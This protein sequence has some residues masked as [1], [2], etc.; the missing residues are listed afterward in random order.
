[1]NN[2]YLKRLFAS[3]QIHYSTRIIGIALFLYVALITS[4]ISDD[5]QITFRSILNFISGLGITFNYGE[6][7]QVFTHPL[8][9]F[10]L[11]CVIAATKE[12]FITTQIVSIIIS[13]LAIIVLT[14]IELKLGQKNLIVASPIIFLAFS[15]AFSDYMTSGLENPLSYLLISLLFYFMFT[16]SIEKNLKY[17]FVILALIVLNRLDIGLIFMAYPL[18]S[19]KYN[20]QYF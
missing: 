12:L 8:W 19:T 16:A 4:W 13:I 20:F 2:I 18:R 17:I 14:K 11:S 15:Q 9:F 5:A 3:Y 7:V 6:R 10:V 1:M